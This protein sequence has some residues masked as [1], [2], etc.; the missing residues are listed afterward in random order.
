M[1]LVTPILLAASILAT[2]PASAK[3]EG[4]AHQKPA[5]EG[6]EPGK[7]TQ[8]YDAALKV[9]KEKHMP[10]FVNFTGSDWCGWCIMMDKKIFSQKEWQDY[11]KENLLLVTIDFP[12]NKEL[13]PEKYKS[14]NQKLKH[15]FGIG[16]FPT[17]I[18][19]DEDGK[20][21]VG[22]LGASR[23]VSPKSF[24]QQVKGALKFSQA[25]IKE[26]TAKFSPLKAKEYM[27][28]LDAHKAAKKN[29][30]DWL[31][32]RPERNDENLKKFDVFREEIQ[33]TLAKIES[34]K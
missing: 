12:N 20:S 19:L 27:G 26:A 32:T 5:T 15:E 30:D 17:F 16:G 14:R 25:G 23:D 10:L 24:I 22:Q 18:V 31:E 8:D 1:R 29:L 2:L 28:L 21:K 4:E 13:V 11:A 7:W 6:A 3:P 34:F 33:N 9:A